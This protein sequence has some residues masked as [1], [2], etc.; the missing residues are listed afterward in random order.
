MKKKISVVILLFLVFTSLTAHV[1]AF[2]PCTGEKYDGHPALVQECRH[3]QTL[4]ADSPNPYPEPGEPGQDPD[5][6]PPP[7][8]NQ[9]TSTLGPQLTSTPRPLPTPPPMPTEP[10]P[11]T[12]WP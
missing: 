6:Y 7:E 10:P 8:S 2:D 1:Q 5:P 3:Q 11:P 4:K 9:P 12:A